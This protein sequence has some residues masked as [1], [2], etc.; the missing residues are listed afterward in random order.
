MTPREALDAWLTALAVKGRRENTIRL[1]RQGVG[2]WLDYCEV[3]GLDPF[4]VDKATFRA[5][6]GTVSLAPEGI[7]NRTTVTKGWYTWLAKRNIAPDCLR[8]YTRPPKRRGGKPRRLP[9]VLG[10]T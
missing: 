1:Y 10:N 5:Y 6:M 4:A 9:G 2:H 3:E 7:Y 8:A